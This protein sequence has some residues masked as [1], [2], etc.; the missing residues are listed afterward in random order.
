MYGGAISGR[1]PRYCPSIEDKIVKFPDA[2]RHQV[3]LEPEGLDTSEM[4]VNGL[5][6]SLPAEVQLAFL[7]TVPGLE[8]VRMTRPGYAIEYDYFPPT[9]LDP[10]LEVRGISRASSWPARSTAPPATR[11]PPARAPWP[12]LNAAARAL[13]LEPVVLAARRRLHRR[14]RWTTW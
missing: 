3:F 6:T 1:G 8:Q 11:R 13:G 5:S 7:R 10:T 12:G 9:Q 4:Y 14:A 2:E